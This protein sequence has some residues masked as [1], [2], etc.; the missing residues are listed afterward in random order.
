VKQSASALINASVSIESI[1]SLLTHSRN[2]S[3]IARI[4]DHDEFIEIYTE[5]FRASQRAEEILGRAVIRFILLRA[6]N[7]SALFLRSD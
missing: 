6:D 7:P 3:K 1:N 2:A 4:C 5:P